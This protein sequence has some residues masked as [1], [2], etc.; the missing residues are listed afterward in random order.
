M[1]QLFT[2]LKNDDKFIKISSFL[3]DVCQK[4]QIFDIYQFFSYI[5]NQEYLY[6]NQEN[7][8]REERIVQQQDGPL[9]HLRERLLFLLIIQF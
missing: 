8:K 4:S 7:E 9:R 5:L 6:Q 1:Q 2:S 3:E